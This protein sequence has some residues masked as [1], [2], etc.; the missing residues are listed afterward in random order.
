MDKVDAPEGKIRVE[1]NSSKPLKFTRKLQTRNKED[2]IIK[3]HYEKLF[4]HCTTCGLMSHEASDC[5]LKQISE[6]NLQAPTRET[7]FDR[8]RSNSSMVDQMG[9]ARPFHGDERLKN[10]TPYRSYKEET[11]PISRVQRSTHSSRVNRNTS[12]RDSRYN[13]YSGDRKQDKPRN[14]HEATKERIWKE[15]QL[16]PLM[17]NDQSPRATTSGSAGSGPKSRSVITCFIEPKVRTPTTETRDDSKV[18]LRANS[19]TQ[20]HIS[21]AEASA[22]DLIPP[23]NALKIASLTEDDNE[24]EDEE[25][26]DADMEEPLGN[27]L[28]VMEEDDL[29]GEDLESIKSMDMETTGQNNQETSVL[30]IEANDKN[31]EEE[32]A[33]DKTLTRSLTRS[34]T[35]TVQAESHRR[36]SPR[37][38]ARAEGGSGARGRGTAKPASSRKL[39]TN[40]SSQ[41]K[42]M[43]DA[44]HP[45]HL[46]Q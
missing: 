34:L 11:R 16:K 36:A 42:G 46:H 30:M 14:Y 31:V 15:K 10:E 23:Y 43:V 38:N 27:E 18:T 45:S 32:N 33:I 9:T 17:I 25:G 20:D 35:P 37:I 2:I 12:N 28:M 5:S 1:M 40:V 29:L 21:E 13:P 22:N 7:F 26:A 44:K 41:K 6:P 4:K 24:N 3:L 39:A 19:A 8:V